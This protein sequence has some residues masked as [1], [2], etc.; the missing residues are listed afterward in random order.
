MNVR[1]C[2]ASLV[3]GATAFSGCAPDDSRNE[4]KPY[5]NENK[6]LIY[7][8]ITNMAPLIEEGVYKGMKYSILNK[9]IAEETRKDEFI[10]IWDSNSFLRVDYNSDDSVKSIAGNLKY[11]EEAVRKIREN[12]TAFKSNFYIK[13]KSK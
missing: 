13:N 3:L 1:K 2:L 9:K 11:Y 7:G 5:Q 8:P 4:V 6:S 12:D 10:E